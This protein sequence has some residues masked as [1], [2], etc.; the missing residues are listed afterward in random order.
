MDTVE[1]IGF[2]AATLSTGAFLPQAIHV[3]RSRDTRAISLLMYSM[4]TVGAALWAAYGVF[5]LQWPIII[6]N[7]VAFCFISV[8]LVMKLRDVMKGRLAAPEDAKPAE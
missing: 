8:I 7:V 3:I 6:A 5:N 1:I 2:A 4:A